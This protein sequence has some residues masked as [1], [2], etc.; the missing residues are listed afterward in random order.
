[1]E[2]DD[3]YAVEGFYLHG[4]H[5]D[6]HVRY[7]TKFYLTDGTPVTHNAHYVKTIKTI[8]AETAKKVTEAMQALRKYARAMEGA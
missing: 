2:E 5:L 7:I 3:G 1:M 4:D 6:V 8:D